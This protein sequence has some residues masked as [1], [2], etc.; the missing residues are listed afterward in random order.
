MKQRFRDQILHDVSHTLIPK[1]VDEALQERG[2][3]P[4]DTPNIK[5]VDLREGQPLKFTAAIETVPPFDPG[6]LSTIALQRRPTVVADEAVDQALGRLRERAAKSEPVEG[7]PVADADTVVLDIERQDPDGERD[8]RTVVVAAGECDQLRRLVDADV[9]A[10]PLAAVVGGEAGAAADLEHVDRPGRAD[11][12]E[13]LVE[14]QPPREPAR[15]HLVLA[16][17]VAGDAVEEL[18]VALIPAIGQVVAL[19]SVHRIDPSG[20]GSAEGVPLHCGSAQE[21]INT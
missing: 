16:R 19:R 17:V 10:D 12:A 20:R 6:D 2:I 11:D 7:R 14:P 8:T 15:L 3:E 21:G 4:V 9:R 5:D 1:A 13:R 18:T